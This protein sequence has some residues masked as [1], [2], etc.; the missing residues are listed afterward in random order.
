MNMNTFK[1]LD[2][3]F[4]EIQNKGYIKAVNNNKN[5]AGPTLENELG[6]TGGDFNI[7][8]FYDIE[9][10]AIR[11]YYAAEFDL[12][13]SRPDGRYYNASQWLSEEF[14]YPDKTFKSVKVFKGDVY[15]S[16]ICP[17]GLFYHFQLDVNEIEK[18]IY[19][20]VFN[21][22]Y[23]FIN[24]D[25]YWDFD[26]LKEK[27]ERKLKKLAIFSFKRI[28]KDGYLYF[29]YYDVKKYELKGFDQFIEC[30]KNGVIY[31]TFKTG[32]YKNGKYAGKFTDHGT[33]FR[34]AKNNI[35]KLF[36]RI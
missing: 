35:N 16:K 15:A 5:S 3:M 13:N 4:Q 18:R 22:K 8:D 7:P 31:V 12:F 33:S 29:K 27:L 20:K 34:I 24:N 21:Y 26:T 11:E 30:I 1:M 19:L 28:E 23:E 25:I 32:V 17:I 36:Y 14:G 9:I 2:K 6:T 10:K